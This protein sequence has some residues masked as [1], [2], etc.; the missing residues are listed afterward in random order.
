MTCRSK[1]CPEPTCITH[2]NDE[3]S[4][5]VSYNSKLW[6]AAWPDFEL[7]RQNDYLSSISICQDTLFKYEGMRLVTTTKEAKRDRSR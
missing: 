4:S 5:V 7:N 3:A 6:T 1:K 2:D